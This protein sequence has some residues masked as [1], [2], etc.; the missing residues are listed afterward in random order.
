MAILTEV[1]RKNTPDQL[2]EEC[3]SAFS[4][5][6]IVGWDGENIMQISSTMSDSDILMAMEVAKAALIGA[7]YDDFSD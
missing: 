5:V 4:D 7:Y 6:L 1:P 2:L 3:K